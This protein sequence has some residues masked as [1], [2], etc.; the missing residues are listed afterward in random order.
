MKDAGKAGPQQNGQHF[1][2][3]QHVAE[4]AA[5]DITEAHARA[6]GIYS[7]VAAASAARLLGMTENIIGGGPWL[8]IPYPN[9][10]GSPSGFGQ[11][12]PFEPPRWRDPPKYLSPSGSHSEWVYYPPNTLR[13]L[14]DPSM[15]LVITEGVKKALCLDAHEHAC[16]A[17]MGVDCWS[18]P[19][20]PGPDGRRFGLLVL[21]RGLR[22]VAWKGRTVA[23]AFDSDAVVKGGV[24]RAERRLARALS[25]EGAA[26]SIVRIPDEKGGAA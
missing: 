9:P 8:V 5:S 3:P 16:V 22:A 4:L 17:L 19:R 12:K 25:D 13:Y 15:P 18:V 7:L 23:I 20:P 21:N 6:A 24:L 26:V 11:V 2:A 10:D 1:L 14:A